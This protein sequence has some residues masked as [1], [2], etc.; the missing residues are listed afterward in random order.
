MRLHDVLDCVCVLA[1]A[2]EEAALFGGGFGGGEAGEFPEEE[3]ARHPPHSAVPRLHALLVAHAPPPG[4]PPQGEEAAAAAVR[5][6][7]LAAAAPALRAQC[8]ELLTASLGVRAPAMTSPASA[9]ALNALHRAIF[10]PRC[11]CAA[12]QGDALAAEYL[13]LHLLSRVHARAEPMAVGAMS[14][15]LRGLGGGRDESAACAAADIV[16]ATVATL[17]PRCL[18]RAVSVEALNAASWSPRKDYTSGRLGSTVLQ[19]AAGTHLVLDETRLQAG[20]L[21]ATGLQNV[22]ALKQLMSEQKID[23]DF[24][25]YSTPLTVDHPV[26]VLSQFK[27]ILSADVAVPLHATAAPRP[28][29]PAD[30]PALAPLRA[31]LAAARALPHGIAPDVGAGAWRC[32]ACVP[33]CAGA[34]AAHRCALCFPRG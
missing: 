3:A 20:T 25:Y 23:V 17:A 18:C 22:Q 13:L 5:A 12:P 30:E 16:A 11:A 28:P 31:F 14:L 2:P 1:V 10:S 26:L 21:C 4:A 29:P 27:S 34:D 9:H 8:I 7:A 24:Q 6:A 32:S 15:N 19:L 33:R